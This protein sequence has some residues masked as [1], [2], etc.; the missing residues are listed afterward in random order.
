MRLGPQWLIL[1]RPPS[2]WGG[3]GGPYPPIWQAEVTR[4]ALEWFN[5]FLCG[6][7]RGVCCCERPF[8]RFPDDQGAEVS[9]RF[10]PV[11]LR[12]QR[13][14][15]QVSVMQRDEEA[16]V[17]LAGAFAQVGVASAFPIA[18]EVLEP[19]P[20]HFRIQLQRLVIWCQDI[21]KVC[22]LLVL[23]ACFPSTR[24]KA[25]RLSISFPIG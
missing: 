22:N 13:P 15:P 4:V 19:V 14:I 6:H 2:A 9:P 20:P 11:L 5:Q 24:G 25:S 1:S 16:V 10:S 17:W 21:E 7:G 18:G 12:R 8:L 23:V 3:S